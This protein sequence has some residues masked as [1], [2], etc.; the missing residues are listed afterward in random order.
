MSVIDGLMG[1]RRAVLGRS[2][3]GGATV[4]SISVREMATRTGDT[5][6]AFV[7][8]ALGVN[9]GSSLDRAFARHPSVRSEWRIARQPS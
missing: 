2:V 1:R 4:G 3:I 5:I 6:A 9:S 8:P 7:G